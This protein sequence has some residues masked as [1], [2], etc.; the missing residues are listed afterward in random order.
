MSIIG[1]H[2]TNFFVL[3]DGAKIAYS[4]FG[5][6]HLGYRTPL[7][8]VCG[9]SNLGGDY[10]RLSMAV[11]SHRPVLV[12]DYRGIGQSTYST[13][14]NNDRLTVETM[15]RDLVALISGIGFE[16]IGVCGYSL[17]GLVAH[18]MLLLPH[19]PKRPVTLP[20][21]V[22]HLILAGT[23]CGSSAKPRFRLKFP[24]PTTGRKPTIEER[25]EKMKDI[26]THL[27][28]PIFLS[29]PKNQ[30]TFLW[31]LN[32]SIDGRPFDTIQKQMRAAGSYD[33]ERQP[34][35][36][37]RD[38]PILVIHG[39]NDYIVPPECSAS[40]LR[41]IPWARKVQVGPK[42][43]MIPSEKFGHQWWDYFD[44]N[45]WVWVIEV[46]LNHGHVYDAKVRAHL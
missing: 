8:L 18:Q 26:V 1:S 29:D 37:P 15:A 19:H 7:V 36:L 40:I 20:F 41:A 31:A 33:I 38:L 11:A 30:E 23:A 14:E 28:D 27:F 32:R 45:V 34:N 4:L 17:G 42:R 22:S 13:P 3:P 10:E 5:T 9:L 6:R 44:V 25:R 21:K 16:E 24:R 2:L 46:F 35:M 12:Y 39:E 43:G